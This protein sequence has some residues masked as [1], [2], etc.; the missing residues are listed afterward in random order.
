MSSDSNQDKTQHKC[1]YCGKNSSESK[2]YWCDSR[3][4]GNVILYSGVICKDCWGNHIECKHHTKSYADFCG[5]ENADREP[6]I[7]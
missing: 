6:P 5:Q 7:G 3:S 1:E 4:F 2:L